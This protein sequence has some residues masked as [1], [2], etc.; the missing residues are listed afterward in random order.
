V[1]ALLATILL[2]SAP[3]ECAKGHERRGAA[4]PDGFD[5]WCEG[6][7]AAGLAWKDGL[8]RL[9]YDDGRLWIEERW[10][11]GRRDGPFVEY[12]RNGRKAREGA[13]DLDRKSGRW[14]VSSD[15]GDVEEE[16]EWRAGVPHGGF[17]SYWPGGRRRTVGRYCGGSQCGT[18]KTW[19]REGREVGSVEYGEQTL[20]P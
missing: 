7:D 6:K 9:Y 11:E 13:F 19:D 5:E 8:A 16:C 15:A 10:R 3:L 17:A 20:L 4:P 12:H 18:W 1:I 14:V 2:A